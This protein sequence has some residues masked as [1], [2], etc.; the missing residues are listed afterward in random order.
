MKVFDEGF[1][2]G[3]K[4]NFVDENNVLIGFDMS[5][6][7]CED[8]GWF[9]SEEVEPYSY[10]NDWSPGRKYSDDE[11][12]PYRFVPDF[13]QDVDSGDLDEGGMVAFKLVADGKPDLYLH[14]YNSHNGYYSHGFT[15]SVGGQVIKD[16]YL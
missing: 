15:V 16:D 5:Q 4:V 12:V 3:E 13:I 9:V 14:L 1:G 8:F 2:F 11:M 7:C 6:D 10:R